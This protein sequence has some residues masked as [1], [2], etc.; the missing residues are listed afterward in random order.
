MGLRQKSALKP[1][2]P[3]E[4]NVD[5]SSLSKKRGAKSKIRRSNIH[6]VSSDPKLTQFVNEP[7]Q[8][9]QTTS[10]GDAQSTVGKVEEAKQS[11]G[12]LECEI[13]SALFPPS[14][15]P[16]SFE[17]I[18]SHLGMTV[19]EVQEIA[20]DALRGLRGPARSRARVSTVWN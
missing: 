20:D 11:L 17:E 15:A 18:A 1:A 19:K 6:L 14:G 16:Q 3:Q 4:G 12:R 7:A 13:I 5:S 10:N 2:P 9:N 8:T